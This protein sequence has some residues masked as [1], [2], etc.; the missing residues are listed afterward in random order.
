MS[1]IIIGV[2]N[3]TF[4]KMDQLDSDATLLQHNGR[5]AKRDIVQVKMLFFPI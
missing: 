2:G 4:E 3:D 1:I 5:Q